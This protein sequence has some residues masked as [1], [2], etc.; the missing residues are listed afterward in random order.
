MKC[1]FVRYCKQAGFHP[2]TSTVQLSMNIQNTA[3]TRYA[4]GQSRLRAEDPKLL[5]GEGRY[6]D[7]ITAR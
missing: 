7:D 4:I 6:T 1:G 2:I 5:R 3:A